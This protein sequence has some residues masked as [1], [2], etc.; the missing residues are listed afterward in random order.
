VA[1]AVAVMELSVKPHPSSAVP[2]LRVELVWEYQERYTIPFRAEGQ[3]KSEEGFLLG[4]LSMAPVAENVTEY[5]FLPSLGNS[6]QTK[7]RVVFDCLLAPRALE[8]LLERRDANARG[9]VVLGVDL[10]LWTVSPQFRVGNQSSGA[11]D[12]PVFGGQTKWGPGLGALSSTIWNG[13]I[14][15]P[16]STWTHDYAPPFGVGRFFTV[17]LPDPRATGAADDKSF[18]GRLSRAVRAV[19]EMAKDVRAGQWTDCV[20]QS[21]RVMELLQKPDEVR[22]VLLADGLTEAAATELMRVI[23]GGFY[24]A[25]KFIHETEKNKTDLSPPLK[26]DKEDAYFVYAT[27]VTLVNLLGRKLS[28]QKPSK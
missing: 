25:S 19:D 11:N 15:I 2:A 20:E 16:A 6:N 22:A 18:E 3:V 26:A 1:L 21:R 14:T 12:V 7:R 17:E 28:R 5:G 4:N 13:S 23:E 10:I 24:Y 8:Y 9:D 27:S